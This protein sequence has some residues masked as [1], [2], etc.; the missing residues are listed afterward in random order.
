M[1]DYDTILVSCEPTPYIKF[2]GINIGMTAYLVDC[3]FQ[4]LITPTGQFHLSFHP[5]HS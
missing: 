4:R 5:L 1:F 2:A 3:I